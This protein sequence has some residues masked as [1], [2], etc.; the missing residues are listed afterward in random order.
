MLSAQ[1]LQAPP[2]LLSVEGLTVGPMGRGLA[3]SRKSG[4]PIFEDVSF[5]LQRGECLALLGPTG[6]GKSLLL[7]A[8]AGC[9][10]PGIAQLQGDVRHLSTGAHHRIGW[11]GQHATATF[12]PLWTVG[13]HLA[14]A[15]QERAW[16]RPKPQLKTHRWLDRM[17]LPWDTS[18]RFADQLS[19]GMARRTALAWALCREASLVLADEPSTG[20]DPIRLLDMA[21]LLENLSAEGVG[22]ILVTHEL[23]LAKRLAHRVARLEDGRLS[24]VPLSQRLRRFPSE[25]HGH[26]NNGTAGA[27]QS[28]L[29]RSGPQ[30]IP[31]ETGVPT[32]Q[33]N[34]VDYEPQHANRGEIHRASPGQDQPSNALKIAEPSPSRATAGPPLLRVENLGWSPPGSSLPVLQGLSWT[35]KAGERVGVMGLS[36]AGKST[37]ARLLAGMLQPVSCPSASPS[38]QGW[39]LELKGEPLWRPGPRGLQAHW[40]DN[41]GVQ[42]VLQ[43]PTAVAHPRL[44]V[45]ESL[46]E[47]LREH[48]RDLSPPEL[49]AQIQAALISAELEHRAEATVGTL[50]GGELRRLGLTRA[51]LAQPA[52]LILDEPTAGLDPLRRE[53]LVERL[54][55]LP[56]SLT[57]ICIS[58]DMGFLAATCE[59]VSLL[60][61][62]AWL[63]HLSAEALRNGH[64][65]S[66]PGGVRHS[67]AA[68][69]PHTRAR[70]HLAQQLIS[71]W[72]AL[73]A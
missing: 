10:P 16:G 47:T 13:Q 72:E 1:A 33:D 8:I 66:V 67:N 30:R 51:L 69:Q 3:T 15:L 20:A 26:E 42:L 41:G 38:A 43:E 63:E 21:L 9:L 18:N 48:L 64:D 40:P 52:L 31:P 17:G 49:L 60:H 45:R 2:S 19:G 62:G 25:P 7:R 56:G 71:S 22:L 28:S 32:R 35:V 58:H 46:A 36:G 54:R 14:D 5:T 37:L 61:E 39:R 55:T 6:A 73:H 53:R 50:S 23:A 11:V 27:S 65:D 44:R 68:L 59:R 34:A 24:F 4:R 57:L 12:D 29:A 70:T